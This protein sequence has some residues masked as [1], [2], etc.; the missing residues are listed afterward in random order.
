MGER[1]ETN[2]GGHGV[3]GAVS[4]SYSLGGRSGGWRPERW[5]R[6]PLRKL[7]GG[8]WVPGNLQRP[9]LWVGAS[10][11]GRTWHLQPRFVK[12]A[13]DG[14][15]EPGCAPDGRDGS[16]GSRA[17]AECVGLR[18]R[19]IQV[20]EGEVTLIAPGPGPPSCRPSRWGLTACHLG[21][22]LRTPAQ[23]GTNG[24][25]TE[26]PPPEALCLGVLVAPARPWELGAIWAH[27]SVNAGLV[28]ALL[29]PPRCPWHT[30]QVVLTTGPSNCDD[31]PSRLVHRASGFWAA[32]EALDRGPAASKFVRPS[33]R[34]SEPITVSTSTQQTS[35]VAAGLTGASHRIS[36]MAP[37]QPPHNNTKELELVP[38][39]HYH[40]WN[41]GAHPVP[42]ALVAYPRRAALALARPAGSG[43]TGPRRARASH[44]HADESR[45]FCSGQLE[46]LLQL[47]SAT[48]TAACVA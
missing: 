40:A 43:G 16:G 32:Q 28:P 17:P 24:A 44:T 8:A 41:I 3:D 33:A 15:S 4:P 21:W 35:F 1:G 42:E 19:L 47:D 13:G 10:P 36:D 39:G 31:P 14:C 30:L 26:A 48:R 27:P 34:P 22:Y 5:H 6:R 2:G 7:D 38:D 37:P 45:R 46:A 9:G 18:L 29:V 25:P 23:L 20:D 11:S 12:P